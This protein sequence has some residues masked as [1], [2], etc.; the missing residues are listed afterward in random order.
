MELFNASNT[1]SQSDNWTGLAVL[2]LLLQN[3]EVHRRLIESIQI[4]GSKHLKISNLDLNI[5]IAFVIKNYPSASLDISE[6]VFR[7]LKYTGEEKIINTYKQ[8]HYE[9]Y[10][11]AGAI[12]SKP[13]I[14][15][16]VKNEIVEKDRLEDAI[17]SISKLSFLLENLQ[18]WQFRTKL[19]NQNFLSSYRVLCKNTLSSYY[20]RFEKL[21]LYQNNLSEES[22]N[23]ANY[24][25]DFLLLQN[26]VKT[27]LVPRLQLLHS[28][29]FCPIL[30]VDGCITV[31]DMI[32]QAINNINEKEWKEEA[33]KKNP[34]FI[35]AAPIV[36]ISGFADYK[37]VS[38]INKKRNY[39]MFCDQ[40]MESEIR[41]TIM[42][43]IHSNGTIKDVWS[44]DADDKTKADMWI[45]ITYAR[46]HVE[47]LFANKS[48]KSALEICQD[49][50]QKNKEGILHLKD[51]LCGK[52]EVI[53]D[54]SSEPEEKIV[55]VKLIIPLI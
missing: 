36:A 8:F 32:A 35:T 17:N 2:V 44:K 41:Y 11:D 14:A 43:A 18:T 55:V 46:E 23:S 16:Y 4:E 9:I 25:K 20:D 40:I 45:N 31:K 15:F 13:L 47:L 49:I 39:W 29:L 12:H 19:N 52:F 33:Q 34:N 5:F 3:K 48:N 28:Y 26:D 30:P 21:I 53:Q 7:L 42:N 27:V 10:N 54:V 6:K 22:V 51:D 1:I 37:P 24:E 38:I 50:E